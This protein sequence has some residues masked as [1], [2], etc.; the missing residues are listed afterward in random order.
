MLRLKDGRLPMSYGYRRAPCG[1]HF[2]LSEDNGKTWAAPIILS[3][4]GTGDLEVINPPTPAILRTARY[5]L[6]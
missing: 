5:K 2:R 3:G 4:D 1:N 6:S